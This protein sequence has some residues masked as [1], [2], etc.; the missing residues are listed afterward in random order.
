MTHEDGNAAR[1]WDERVLSGK[2]VDVVRELLA[3]VGQADEILTI[4]TRLVARNEDLEKLIM[5]LRNIKNHHEHISRAQLA[6]LVMQAKPAATNEELVKADDE[7]ARAAQPILDDKSAQDAKAKAAR[8]KAKADAKAAREKAKAEGEYVP[9]PRELPANAE[10]V[11]NDIEVPADQRPCPKCGGQRATIG[12]EC[13]PV[14]ELIPA[15]VIVRMDRRE[16]LA[17]KACDG[18]LVRAPLGDKIV[19]GGRYGPTMVASLVVDKYDDGLALHRSRARLLR[20]GLD[21]PVSTMADQVRWSA[22][23]LEPLWRYSR[24]RILAADVMHLDGTSLPT[25][26]KKLGKAHLGTLWG[27]VGRTGSERVAAYLYASTGKARGQRRDAQGNLLELGPL[28]ILEL[29]R[30]PVVLDAAGTFDA[31]FLRPDIHEIGCNMH[32]RRYFVKALEAGDKRAAHAIRAFKALYII[33]ESV[34]GKERSEVL[35]ARQE[36]SVPIY[37]ALMKWVRALETREPPRSSLGRALRYLIN[38]EIALRRFL[39][40]GMLPI[41][42]GE[43][44]RLHRRPAIMRMNSLFAGSLEG[45][46]RAAIVMSLLGSCRLAGVHPVAYLADIL[47]KL[48]R[49]G[50]KD[51]A[52]MMPSA[53]KIANGSK[54]LL[55]S[56]EHTTID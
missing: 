38:H 32:A 41:D 45:G 15:Q 23:L 3:K 4:V 44:E 11:L 40:D 27:M 48:Q 50:P 31:A 8:E 22:D 52:A 37:D 30:G 7:L 49:D 43:V 25:L 28:D 14:I 46:R 13:T 34:R 6:L 26:I 56:P 17:C 36:R 33:E 12:H 21:M 54:S 53:W 29:R 18:E 9:P 19:D 1:V 5:S 39:T 20:L 35:K 24:E 55:S 42:N 2:V 51:L 10:Q 47:P 16:K